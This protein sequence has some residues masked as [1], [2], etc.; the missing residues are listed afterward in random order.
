MVLFQAGSAP[1]NRHGRSGSLGYRQALSGFYK[2]QQQRKGPHNAYSQAG[3]LGFSASVRVA[4]RTP[5]ESA[6]LSGA[7]DGATVAPCA[8]RHIIPPSRTAGWGA[9]APGRYRPCHSSQSPLI[10]RSVGPRQCTTPPRCPR[11]LIG[12]QFGQAPMA[13][14][15]LRDEL[16]RFEETMERLQRELADTTEER[17]RLRAEVDATR[18]AEASRAS[19]S[20]T[21]QP[22]TQTGDVLAVDRVSVMSQSTKDC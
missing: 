11:E 19:A 12:G 9:C 22:A 3:A 4:L 1:P 13:T 15:V 8:Y 20:S 6:A 16:L 2:T 18:V 21:A 7:G 10:G 5:R 14:T 17:D